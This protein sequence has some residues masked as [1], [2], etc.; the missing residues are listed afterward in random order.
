MLTD[1]QTRFLGTPLVPL[2]RW[3]E[4]T[5]IRTSVF[6]HESQEQ[7]DGPVGARPNPGPD[8]WTLIMIDRLVVLLFGCLFD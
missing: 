1:V 5:G 7:E 2:R 3:E 4:G 8:P 6:T